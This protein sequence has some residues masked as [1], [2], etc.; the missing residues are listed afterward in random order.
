MIEETQLSL[1]VRVESVALQKA[2]VCQALF[3]EQVVEKG[4]SFSHHSFR[5]VGQVT[6]DFEQDLVDEVRVIEEIVGVW[7]P[8]E[9]TEGVHSNLSPGALH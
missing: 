3:E 6:R 7:E 9:D 5:V 8:R 1:G 2:Q 4:T